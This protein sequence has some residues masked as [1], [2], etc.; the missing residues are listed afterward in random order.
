[1]P[2]KE[3]EALINDFRDHA[4]AKIWDIEDLGSLGKKLGIC[5]YYASRP[6]TKY[7]EVIESSVNVLYYL[8]ANILR[9]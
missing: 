3:S 7:C 9:L 8:H 5:P 1:M 4:L 2:T 6:A